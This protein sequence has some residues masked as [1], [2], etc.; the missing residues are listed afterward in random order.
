MTRWLLE[1]ICVVR[2]VVGQV[3]VQRLALR[4][5]LHDALQRLLIGFILS[6]ATAMHRKKWPEAPKRNCWTSRIQQKKCKHVGKTMAN[7]GKATCSR[8][9]LQSPVSCCTTWLHAEKSAT[10]TCKS[11][12]KFRHEVPTVRSRSLTE[13]SRLWYFWHP[14]NIS[15]KKCWPETPSPGLQFWSPQHPWPWRRK[16]KSRRIFGSA[17]QKCPRRGWRPV[18]PTAPVDTSFEHLQRLQLARSVRLKALGPL[19]E[20]MWNKKP[21]MYRTTAPYL[22]GKSMVSCKFSL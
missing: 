17:F 22:M 16:T 6:M 4:V 2:K 14:K 9:Y 18:S 15:R 3:A 12:A 19:C 5:V 8:L 10:F 1:D 20:T 21:L 11:T 13:T 7:H